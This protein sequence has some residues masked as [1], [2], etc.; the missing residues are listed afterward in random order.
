MEACLIGGPR[1]CLVSFW[2]AVWDAGE[3]W[4]RAHPGLQS[5]GARQEAVPL[6]VHADE[7]QVGK[8]GSNKAYV[9]SVSSLAR[10]SAAATKF[11]VASLPVDKFTPTTLHEFLRWLVHDLEALQAGRFPTSDWRG[12]PLGT[13]R[14]LT[15]GQTIPLR[16]VVVGVKGDQKWLQDAYRWPRSF[17][18]NQ[19]CRHCK[20]SRVP[21]SHLW[22]D[23]RDSAGWQGSEEPAPSEGP[24]TQLTGAHDT[25]V[26][27]DMFH[28]LWVNGVGCDLAG[29]VLCLLA[30]VRYF[31]TG[32]AVAEGAGGAVAARN[33]VGPASGEVARGTAEADQ[34]EHEEDGPANLV[35]EEQLRRAYCCF[36]QWCSA[37]EVETTMER[38]SSKTVH[39]VRGT[40]VP[41]LSGKGCDVRLTL[42]W[43]HNLLATT[44][45]AARHQAESPVNLGQM[46]RCI[47]LLAWFVQTIAAE[48]AILTPSV[49]LHLRATGRQF[50]VGY[51][52]LAGDAVR[53]SSTL[54]K[55]RPKLHLLWHLADRLRAMNPKVTSCM[56]DESFMGVVGRVAKQCHR[57]S[58]NLR[59]LQRYLH[60]LATQIA[61]AK[62]ERAATALVRKKLGG[63]NCRPAPPTAKPNPRMQP[64]MCSC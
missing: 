19:I 49:V 58:M 64:R 18:H 38:F 26:F 7:I 27:D 9:I 39:C 51:L 47:H 44:P 17:A 41:Q 12:Q 29:S 33:G 62:G 59:V 32:D 23:Y 4:A 13:Q 55:V 25:G 37:N 3:P 40:S 1:T 60:Q 53:S 15:A 28:L 8:Q 63:A 57:A 21:G 16:V 10:G 30:R 2:Q 34:S 35:V 45:P 50:V 20:A 11:L 6:W 54:F 52:R 36:R 46:Q 22:T 48:P 31:G 14:A 42:L 56:S 5:E 43:L 61:V 24:L